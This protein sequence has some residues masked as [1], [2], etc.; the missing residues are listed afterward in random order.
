[1][2]TLPAKS[3]LWDYQKHFSSN[4]KNQQDSLKFGVQSIYITLIVII[5]LLVFYYVLLLNTNATQWY[6]IVALEEIQKQLILEDE[7]LDVKIAELE[8][9]TT[10]LKNDAIKNMENVTESNHLVVK[11]NIQ[12]VYNYE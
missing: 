12:Y 3:V 4:R 9:L 10:I 7:L 5:A 6:E 11:E 1:M 2:T 8:S